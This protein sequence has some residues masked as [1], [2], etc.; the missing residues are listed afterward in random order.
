LP[1]LV[2][3]FGSMETKQRGDSAALSA[4]RQALEDHKWREAFDLLSQADRDDPL[5]PEDLEALAQAAWFTAQPDLAIEAKERAFKTY[6]DRG[7]QI[8]AAALA[9]DLGREY[10]MKQQLSIASAWA[11][12]GER[13]LRDQP[14]SYAHGYMALTQSWIAEGAGDVD[15]GIERAAK[16]VEIGARF[17]DA[18]LQAWALQQQG[19]LLISVGRTDEGFPLMEEATIAAVNGELSPFTAGVAYCGMIAACRNTTDYRRASEWTEAAHRWCERQAINGFPGV[20]RVH[21]AEIVGLQGALERAELEL[22]QATKELA[23]YNATF[24]LADGF[25]ALGAIR[26]R[27]GDLEGSEEALRQAHSLGRV[28][29][30]AL[31]LI[32]LNEG[33]AKAALTA[34]NSALAEETW[35]RWARARMLPA[36]VE[37]AVA[38]RDLAR[39]RTAAEELSGIADA[40]ASPALHAAKHDGWGR[41][42]LAEG[43]AEEAIREVRTAIRHWQE[44]GAPYEV[45]K[46]RVVLASALRRLDQDDQADLELETAKAEFDRLGAVRDA[47]TT[48]DALRAAAGRRSAAV[49]ARKTFVFTDIVG[50]TNLAEAMGDEA[51]EHLLRW[52]NETLRSLFDRYG[53]EVVVSTGDGF[54]VAFDSS[55]AAVESAVAVQRA[56]AEHRRTHG[57]APSVRIGAHAT[58]ASQ[59]GTEYSGMGV[60]VAAR[61]AALAEGGQV[62]VSAETAAE[63]NTAYRISD[64]RSVALKGVSG[65]LDV[66][67]IDWS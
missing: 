53:G 58:E 49:T 59:R 16:A 40:F 52:H 2:G 4:G 12:R 34:I 38:A 1:S 23:A 37:I 20:C 66:V 51:W 33:K 63:A 62:L 29:Q 18:D 46:D 50:S 26:L 65:E 5:A 15:Q 43:G 30:P 17:A 60:H 36:Q 55:R 3:Q 22:Q 44:V 57:F 56:L 8:R 21:R 14:E 41:V 19:R 39:A 13:L 54:F 35:D 9:F 27:M 10:F 48:D 47:A 28:P 25:Y 45:A 31:A 32:R 67:S 24:P 42:L 11:S 64:P 61:I 7:N 6:L